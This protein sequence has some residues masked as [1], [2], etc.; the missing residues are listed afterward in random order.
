MKSL[1]VGSLS[2]LVIA[3]TSVPAAQ[4][5]TSVTSSGITGA[6]YM[7]HLVNLEVDR[8]SLTGL[9]IALPEQI[10]ELDEVQIFNQAGETVAANT[11]ISDGQ[12]L[13]DFEQ[14]IS[15]GNAL[16]LKFKGVNGSFLPGQSL[17][18][19]ISAQKEGLSQL[20]PLRTAIVR[21]P[22]RD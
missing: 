16:A 15:P 10:E 5:F 14:A 18:Y 11:T 17:S 19:L 13:I 22:D 7:T 8:G 2:T 4:A 9:N 3:F 12:I 1:I 20:I 21:I 6:N